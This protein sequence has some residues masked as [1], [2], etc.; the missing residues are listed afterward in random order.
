MVDVDD[1]AKSGQVVEVYKSGYRLGDIVLRAAMVGV[2][3]AS[4]K[5]DN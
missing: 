4:K 3:N 5:S 2:G 1:P